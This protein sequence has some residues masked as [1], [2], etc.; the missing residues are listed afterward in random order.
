MKNALDALGCT[1]RLGRSARVEH[2]GRSCDRL[3]LIHI[4]STRTSN[5]CYYWSKTSAM[6]LH[7]ASMPRRQDQ[8]ICMWCRRHSSASV[9]AMA[10]CFMHVPI[11]R[12]HKTLVGQRMRF[13][14]PAL[15]KSACSCC[16]GL[17]KF[18]GANISHLAWMRFWGNAVRACA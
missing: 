18:A 4:C 10:A 2:H 14:C 15:I 1:V 16:R 5:R 3:P 7:S 9:P 17:H 11:S 8:G 13:P 12:R 6:V